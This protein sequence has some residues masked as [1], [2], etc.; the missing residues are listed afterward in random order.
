MVSV[1]NVK[2]FLCACV[3][4]R[5][6]TLQCVWCRAA[7]WCSLPSLAGALQ[8]ENSEES[9]QGKYECVAVN[10]AGT[11]YSAPAN[12]YVRGKSPAGWLW[13]CSHGQ[14]C[15]LLTLPHPGL[16]LVIYFMY[17]CLS[18][19]QDHCAM[20]EKETKPQK[21]ENIWWVKSFWSTGHRVNCRVLADE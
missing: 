9:D 2:E 3:N 18:D 6:V 10:R 15:F 13:D 20:S 7:P 16:S 4:V 19:V 17:R 8:I 21:T 14:I 5:M 11:R 1:K 12:L